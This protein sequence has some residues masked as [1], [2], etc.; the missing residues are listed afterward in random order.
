ML[1]YC[2]T[3]ANSLKQALGSME[4]KSRGLG[5]GSLA[6]G[7]LLAA[8][9]PAWGEV[10]QP[11]WEL[12]IIHTSDQEAGKKALLDIPGMIAVMDQLDRLPYP[13]TLKVT[14]GDLFIAGPFM[15]ASQY[16]YTNTAD[17]PSKKPNQNT[18][19]P[20]AMRAGLADIIINNNLGWQAAVIGN[21]EF[22]GI[23]QTG[24]VLNEGNFFQLIGRNPNLQN[25]DGK[26]IGS[27]AKTY[28]QA[29]AGIGKE[30]YP[31]ANFPYLS[32]NLNLDSF[33]ANIKG[34]S[35]FKAY[36]LT[37][38]RQTPK[39]ASANT[40]AHSSV[41][42][43]GGTKVGIIGAT[44]PFLPD[45]VGG[46]EPH[47][48]VAG[49]YR[50]KET[51]PTEQAAALKPLISREVEALQKQGINK[52]V[53]LTH[54]Q[55]SAVDEALTRQ[56]VDADIGVDVV[57]GGGSH[58]V[59][60]P[61]DGAQRGMLR[62]LDQSSVIDQEAKQRQ[63][64]QPA[65][66]PYPMTFIG[67][68]NKAKA[69]YVNGG[70]NYEYLNQLVV[71]FDT[72]GQVV[73]HDANN[74]RPWKTDTT[75][76]IGMLGK[77]EWQKLPAA[78]QRQQIQNHILTQSQ[79]PDYRNAIATLKSVEGYINSLDRLQ[80]GQ[81]N[82]WLNGSNADVRS[83]ETNLGNLVAD[84][85]LW[86]GQEL[87]RSNP[88]LAD[89]R[90]IDV[91]FINGGGIRDMIGTEQVMPDETVHRDPPEANAILGKQAGEISKLD[92]VNSLR[93]DNSITVG[94]ITSAQLKRSAEAMVAEV[95]HG[96]FGQISGFRFRY[97]PSR[98]RG[99]RVL[100]MELTK[101]KRLA[102]GRVDGRTQEQD[103]IRSLVRQGKV[104][105]PNETLG[106]V[107]ITYLAEGGDGQG[108]AK[109][110]QNMNH[111]HWIGIAGAAPIWTAAGQAVPKLLTQAEA[112]PALNS[113]LQRRELG[114]G[115]YREALGAYLEANHGEGKPNP[116]RTPDPS[117]NK[118]IRITNT[119]SK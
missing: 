67:K 72:K 1:S 32:V 63:T 49:S 13:N 62:G 113:G 105:N 99:E 47:N 31:G 88:A 80:Y 15:N 55:E 73:D 53:L 39:Q 7:L 26:G 33:K 117:P 2:F 54:L 102:D 107:T 36:G 90:S 41:V 60:G 83:K 28:K 6:L 89:I 4:G 118:T 86:Y 111:A 91:A 46:I 34:E 24:G 8:P 66:I 116:I 93:F 61:T 69:Y 104:V 77:Q 119:M 45:I 78:Q 3:R 109:L 115:S 70:S 85:L 19:E 82:V 44:T 12:R 10:Q 97:D 21:H 101:P 43:V 58:K 94:T 51:S 17:Y 92:V 56:L 22:D 74:S 38:A 42:L 9:W 100:E 114:F 65:L 23:S 96:G 25:Y 59:M 75:G 84:S 76:V 110:T 5:I 30:G 16:L 11:T 81:T 40:L 108:G 112:P 95:R 48:M 29:G 50:T 103:V 87:H 18:L 27:N 64:V 79:N 71:R 37:D 20:L 57:I 52:I 106:L 98:P 68:G 14:S 35:I